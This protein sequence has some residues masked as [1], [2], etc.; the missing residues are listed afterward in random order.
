MLG[1]FYPDLI[2]FLTTIY[3]G[4]W[5]ITFV[6]LVAREK[7]LQEFNAPRNLA[8]LILGIPL[9]GILLCLLSYFVWV[10]LGENIFHSPDVYLSW[11]DLFFGVG[12]LI[13]GSV[14]VWRSFSIYDFVYL[15]RL[16]SKI[17]DIWPYNL[18]NSHH[19]RVYLCNFLVH[20][21]HC[22]PH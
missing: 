14:L 17:P 11:G 3:L 12:Y 2:P 5:V 18:W 20:N 4:L 13:Y 16:C 21:C 10:P 6:F 15:G 8:S 22:P 9:T 7:Y 19:I 1:S